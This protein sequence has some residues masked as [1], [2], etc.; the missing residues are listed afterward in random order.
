MHVMSLRLSVSHYTNLSII[1]NLVG[2]ADMYKNG[3]IRRG[4]HEMELAVETLSPSPRNLSR[5]KIGHISP[6]RHIR[7]CDAMWYQ[8]LQALTR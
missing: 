5:E 1:N 3:L 2:A 4:E 7:N 8:D 6:C